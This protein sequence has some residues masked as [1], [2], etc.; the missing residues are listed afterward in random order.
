PSE[1]AQWKEVVESWECDLSSKNLFE[2]MTVSMMLAAVHLKL[3]Q[4]EAKDLK[5]G[6]NNSLHMD[7]SPSV[8]IL[9]GMD[10][11]EQQYV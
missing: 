1:V 11:E 9:S 6:L 8:L 3:S 10:L 4:Q 2:I 5:N 7:I